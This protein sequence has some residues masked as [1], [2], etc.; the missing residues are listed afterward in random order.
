MEPP[1][2][3]RLIDANLNRICEG[4][5]VLE[6]CFRFA[7]PNPD[8]PHAVKACATRCVTNRAA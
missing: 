6:D 3:A 1:D 8:L 7:A 2:F 4:L 5:R